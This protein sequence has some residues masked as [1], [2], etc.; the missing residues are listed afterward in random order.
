MAGLWAGHSASLIPNLVR[1]A[2]GAE[3]SKHRVSQWYHILDDSCPFF[4]D[5]W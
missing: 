3:Q 5:E 4:L 2:A 1:S